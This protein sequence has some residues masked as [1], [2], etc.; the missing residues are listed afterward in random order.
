YT[1]HL[2]IC[3]R[4]SPFP[5]TTLFRSNAVSKATIVAAVAT[6]GGTIEKLTAPKATADTH[7]YSTNTVRRCV[8]PKDSNR[9][10]MCALSA[11]NGE[12]P[13]ETRRITAQTKSKTGTKTAA[14]TT[15]KG[16]TSATISAVPDSGCVILPDAEVDAAAKSTPRSMAP[17]S[18]INIRE[19][20]KLCGKKPIH[21]PTKPAEMIAGG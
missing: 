14:V 10:C 19:G 9:W 11:A 6:K 17:D 5:Y 13:C 15:I 7:K 2:P 20:S 8:C 3:P 21:M 1:S 16:L 12:F 18:P 4:P